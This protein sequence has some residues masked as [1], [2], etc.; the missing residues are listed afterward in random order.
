MTFAIVRR[1]AQVALD[2]SD[3]GGGIPEPLRAHVFDPYVTTRKSGEGMGLGLSISRK[4]M[5]D[6]GGELQLVAASPAG[7]TF[8]L[9]FG[10]M[11]C[12]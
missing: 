1:G 7:T 2:V 8:R 4:I 3:S 11:K 9:I 5:L 6:H 10:E 12:S